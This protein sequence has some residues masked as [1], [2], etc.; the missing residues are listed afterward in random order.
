VYILVLTGIGPLHAQTVQ[1]RFDDANNLALQGDLTEAYSAY[2]ALEAEGQI[3][4]KLYYNLGVIAFQ[5]DSLSVSKLYHIAAMRHSETR[6]KAA[7]AITFLDSRFPQR[8]AELPKLPWEQ[9]FDFLLRTFGLNLLFGS[10]VFIANIGIILYMLGWW[11]GRPRW[12]RVAYLSAA[13]YT[14]TFLSISMYI[15]YRE[16]RYRDG[17]IIQGQ[18]AVKEEADSNSAVVSQAYEGFRFQVDLERS[19]Q[20]PGWLYVRMSNGLY[21][22]LPEAAIRTI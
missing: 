8:I 15:D 5:L 2:K 17:V 16:Q 10:V 19:A 12:L 1:S 14:L 11:I 9:F 22:W 18:Y 20:K 4:G 7:E 3:S 21:G 6:S 13:L